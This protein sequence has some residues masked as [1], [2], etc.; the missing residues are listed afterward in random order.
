MVVKKTI[1]AKEAISLPDLE[2]RTVA[3]QI[4]GYDSVLAELGARIIDKETRIM[5]N[6]KS[7]CYK[8]YRINLKDDIATSDS[9]INYKPA[10]FVRVECPS[11]GRETLLRVHPRVD[12]VE[13][14]IAWTFGMT[15]REYMLDV[16]T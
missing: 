5:P 3:C 7:L 12:T 8:L 16:E 10:K 4:I 11:T 15:Q 14:A 9:S 13:E 2:Q 6:G 1:T